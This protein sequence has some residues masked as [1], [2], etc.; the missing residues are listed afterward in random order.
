MLITGSNTNIYI[1]CYRVTVARKVTSGC[2][3]I[4]KGL[5]TILSAL[6]P[7]KLVQELL[8]TP[9]RNTRKRAAVPPTIDRHQS[10]R[11]RAV[12]DPPPPP[13]PSPQ[14]E[15]DEE[16]EVA[17]AAAAAA[18]AGGLA[19]GGKDPVEEPLPMMSATGEV[20]LHESLETLK[21]LASEAAAVVAATSTAENVPMAAAAA[22]IEVVASLE[23][24][25]VSA[26]AK[27]AEADKS[28]KFQQQQQQQQQQQEEED[29][30]VME[31]D[32]INLSTGSSV[33]QFASSPVPTILINTST[34][35]INR[36]IGLAIKSVLEKTRWTI[37]DGSIRE[38][39]LSEDDKLEWRK[40]KA[41]AL[42]QE[43]AAEILR[44][45]SPSASPI[46]MAGTAFV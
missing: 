37:G 11:K 46:R 35:H 45:F 7:E 16:A 22:A 4:I 23:A 41:E 15:E 8:N 34:R 42:G 2:I 25:I 9:A 29:S 27:K 40:K 14:E 24:E 1:L 20:S 6:P 36:N 33:I 21:M 18:V 43:F 32:L 13:P 26:S 39:Q 30:V 38:D 31:E 17:A 44:T 12:H 5:T 28:V 3:E 19:R 10:P